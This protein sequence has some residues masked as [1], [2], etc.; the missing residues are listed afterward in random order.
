MYRS[1]SSLLAEYHPVGKPH[2]TV[3]SVSRSVLSPSAI[4]S[5]TIVTD[6][7][8]LRMKEDRGLVS[9]PDSIVLLAIQSRNVGFNGQ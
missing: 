7:S 9:G 6:S 2:L 8:S 4:V 3:S 5:E 1:L